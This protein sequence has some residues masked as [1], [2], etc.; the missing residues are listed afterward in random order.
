M[1]RVQ[2]ILKEL[3]HTPGSLKALHTLNKESTKEFSALADLA[4]N[5]LRVV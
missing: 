2:K 5:W 4:V 3:Q 1:A